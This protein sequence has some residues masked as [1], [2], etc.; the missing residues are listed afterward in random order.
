M[1]SKRYFYWDPTGAPE[2]VDFKAQTDCEYFEIPGCSACKPPR[3]LEGM[4]DDSSLQEWLDQVFLPSRYPIKIDELTVDDQQDG[5]SHHS[6]STEHFSEH[7]CSRARI[8]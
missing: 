8:L 6:R 1:E 2:A 4:L 7:H 3:R 5:F